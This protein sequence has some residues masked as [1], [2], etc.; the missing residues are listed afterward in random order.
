MQ[1]FNRQAPK[2]VTPVAEVKFASLDK[3]KTFKQKDG[4]ITKTG[5]KDI[6]VAFDPAGVPAHAKF[7]TDLTEVTERGLSLLTKAQQKK[8]N[9]PYSNET[10]EDDAETGRVLV[11]MTTQAYDK[12][13]RDK[14]VVVVDA[15]KN[16]VLKAVYGGSQVR[17]ST[18]AAAYSVGNVCGVKLYLNAVQVIELVTAGGG[19]NDFDVEDGYEDDGVAVAAPEQVTE[20][21]D[22]DSE[23]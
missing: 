20:E 10:D 12:D 14:P 3:E 2:W 21:E 23:F 22:D 17:V 6:T 4:S 5:K 11:K 16:P 7:I 19:G 13:G 1:T 8:A 15:K 9:L 18:K